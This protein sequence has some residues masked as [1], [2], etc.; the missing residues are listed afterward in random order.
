MKRVSARIANGARNARLGSDI[1]DATCPLKAFRREV[2]AVLLPMNGLHRF[3][4]DLARTAGF[5]VVEVPVGHRPRLHGRSKYGVWN[6]LFRGIRD[7]RGVRWMTDR[8]VRYEA[9]R[10]A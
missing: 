4:P 2:G 5:R 6:R 3:L 10:S 9:T 1:H 7:L 8:W